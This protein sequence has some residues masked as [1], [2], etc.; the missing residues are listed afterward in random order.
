MR[1][2]IAP[3]RSRSGSRPTRLLVSKKPDIRTL[4][5]DIEKTW[6]AFAGGS[7]IPYLGV[8]AHADWADKNPAL[9]EQ[10]LRHLQGGRRMDREESRRSGAR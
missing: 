10:A 3:T 9:V 5:L 8:G 6:K 1:S 7:R 2:P 4:D